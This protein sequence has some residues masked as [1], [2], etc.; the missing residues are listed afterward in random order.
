M[1]RPKTENKRKS[2]GITIDIELNKKLEKYL[3]EK[4]LNKSEYIEF[5]IKQDQKIN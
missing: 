1:A 3:E 2:I 5:L 4:R